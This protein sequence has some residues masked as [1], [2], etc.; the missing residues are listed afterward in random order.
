MI[1]IGKHVIKTWSKTQKT[2]A[3]SSGEAEMVAEAKGVSEGLG[4][5]QRTGGNKYKL[6]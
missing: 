1:V 5:K 3:L 6:D 2:V 4:V